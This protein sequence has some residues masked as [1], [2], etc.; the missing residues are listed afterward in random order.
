M[1]QFWF[2]VAGGVFGFA[3][4]A[5]ITEWADR[6]WARKW[7]TYARLACI[8]WAGRTDR[9]IIQTDTLNELRAKLRKIAS[10][11]TAAIEAA[12]DGTPDEWPADDY[13]EDCFFRAADAK[14]G[15]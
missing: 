5:F 3:F 9:V 7:G 4:W 12:C 6:L 10:D 15:D 11:I 2:G 1:E 8:N 13:Y 14:E